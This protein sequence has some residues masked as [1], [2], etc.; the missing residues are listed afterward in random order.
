MKYFRPIF[1]VGVGRSGT[2]LL[3][4]MLNV[5][6]DISFPPET[7]FIRYYLIKKYNYDSVKNKLIEDKNLKK[8]NLDLVDLVNASNSLKDFY[9][10]LLNSYVNRKNKHFAGDKD[11]KNVECL[12][13]IKENFPYSL[14]IHIYRDPRAVIA[15]RIKAKWSMSRPFW[16]QL[17]AYKAQ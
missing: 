11:P 5:H 1:I 16:Q 4:S 14:I 2:S 15:S 6:K 3:Q 10:S 9:V 8:L 17:L 7:Y 12:R 13:V